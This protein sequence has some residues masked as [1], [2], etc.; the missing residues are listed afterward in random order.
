M[1]PVDEMLIK[2]IAYMIRN[3]LLTPEEKSSLIDICQKACGQR[4]AEYTE[5][6]L[7]R[8]VEKD[9]KLDEELAKAEAESKNVIEEI[10][11]LDIDGEQE[12]DD[13]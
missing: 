5:D 2:A 3:D 8:R 4:E 6:I 10:V 9:E 12:K 7:R 11:N 1:N 13:S